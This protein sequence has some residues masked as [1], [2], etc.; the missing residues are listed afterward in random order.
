[1]NNH[2]KKDLLLEDLIDNFDNNNEKED[3]LSIQEIS[4]PNFSEKR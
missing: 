1:M 3:W 4:N 2:Y